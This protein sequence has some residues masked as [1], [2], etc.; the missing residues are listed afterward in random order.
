M[1]K[2][3]HIHIIDNVI[4]TQKIITLIYIIITLY[5]NDT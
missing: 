2:D 3:I 5:Y 1:K 4:D